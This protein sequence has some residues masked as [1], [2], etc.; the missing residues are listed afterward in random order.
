MLHNDNYELRSIAYPKKEMYL[1]KAKDSQYYVYTIIGGSLA[2]LKR[3]FINI[4]GG[5]FWSPNVT[6]IELKGINVAT[7]GTVTEKIKP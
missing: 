3:I 2:V 4:D 7:G 1:R 5:S 6:Y